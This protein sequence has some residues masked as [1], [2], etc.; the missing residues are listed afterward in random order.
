MA[1]FCGDRHSCHADQVPNCILFSLFPRREI[2]SAWCAGLLIFLDSPLMHSH[3]L[4]GDCWGNLAF[5][6]EYVLTFVQVSVR[7][8]RVFKVCE[9]VLGRQLDACFVVFNNECLR[10]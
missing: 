6:W 8:V 10:V 5:F 3:V 4:T 1:F 9:C 2:P 7:G